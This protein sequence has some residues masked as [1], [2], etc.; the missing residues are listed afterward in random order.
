MNASVSHLDAPSGVDG[1]RDPLEQLADDFLQRHRRGEKP[2]VA[3]Y[4][5][6]FPALAEQIRGVFPALLILEQAGPQGSAGSFGLLGD[7]NSQQRTPPTIGDYQ[8][9]REIGRGAM[10]IVYEA[11]QQSLD[12]RVAL[13]ILPWHASSDSQAVERFRREAKAAARLHHTNIVPVFEVGQAGDVCFYTMQCIQG[14]SLDKVIVELR[15]LVRDRKLDLADELPTERAPSVQSLAL[16]LRD[17]EFAH[18]AEPEVLVAELA[19]PETIHLAAGSTVNDKP[20]SHVSLADSGQDHLYRS[21]AQIGRQIAEA[22]AY[23]HSRGV[24]HRDIKPSNVLLDAAGVAWVTDFGL[25]KLEDVAITRTGDILGTL[26]YMAPERFQGECDAAADVYS[27]GVTL[28][29]LLALKPPHDGAQRAELI[30]QITQRDPLPLRVIDPAVPRDLELIIHKALEREPQHRYATAAALAEDLRRFLA[31]E[32]ILGR[33]ISMF[34]RFARWVRHNRLLAASLI[35][36]AVLLLLLVVATTL[37]GA[38]FRALAIQEREAR[39]DTTGHLYRAL[40]GEARATRL[41]RREGFRSQAWSLLDQARKLD[42]EVVNPTELRAEAIQSLGDFVGLKPQVISGFPTDVRSLALSPDAK[43]IAVGLASGVIQW[44]KAD[45]GELI[46]KR[47]EHFAAVTRLTFTPEGGLLSADARGVVRAWQRKQ[48]DVWESAMLSDVRSPLLALHAGAGEQRL[49]AYNS[50]HVATLLTIDDLQTKRR[51][52]IDPGLVITSA[53]FNSTASMLAGVSGDDIFVWQTSGG[54]LIKRSTSQLGPLTGVSFSRD[55]QLLLCTGEQGLAVFDLPELRQQTFTR[56]EQLVAGAF[57]RDGR[58]VAVASE[59]RRVTLWSVFGNREIAALSHPGWKPLHT[60]AFSDDERLLASADADSVRIWNLAGASD[61]LNLVGHTSG[62]TSLDFSPDGRRLISTSKDR[63]LSLWDAQSGQRLAITGLSAT[64]QSAVFSSDGRLL[65]AGDSAGKLAIFDAASLAHVLDVP[66]SLG[67][68]H[69][70]RFSDDGKYFAASGAKGLVVWQVK[71]EPAAG[72][73][74]PRIT[75][76]EIKRIDD[77]DCIALAVSPDSQFLAWLNSRGRIGVLVLDQLAQWPS[78]APRAL[79]GSYNLAFLGDSRHLLLIDTN[80]QLVQWDVLGDRATAVIGERGD[81]RGTNLALGPNGQWV[82]IDAEPLRLS[83]WDLV[84]KQQAFVFR[85]ER[86]AISA[87]AWSAA[88]NRLAFG[89]QDGQVAIWDLSVVRKEL[90]GI[91]LD[92][93]N[94]VFEQP[95][96]AAAVSPLQ[97]LTTALEREPKN[98]MLLLRRASL[99]LER[100]NTEQSLA[101]LSKALE[102]DEQSETALVARSNLYARLGK[103]PEAAADALKAV[104]FDPESIR[105][106]RATAML[107][108]RAGDAARYHEHCGE[109]AERFA[110]SSDPQAVEQLLRAALLLPDAT[111]AKRLPRQVLETAVSGFGPSPVSRAEAYT[112]LALLEL[113]SGKAESALSF[114]HRAQED[115]AYSK[116]PSAQSLSFLVQAVAEQYVGKPAVARESLKASAAFAGGIRP[117]T[118]GGDFVIANEARIVLEILTPEAQRVVK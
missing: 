39:V 86:S 118:P 24:I 22:L 81:L 3:E 68:L 18:D 30:A 51:V 56:T 117:A 23:A 65:A 108:A 91:E 44:H 89:T 49:I 77:V 105:N 59:G 116:T 98:A 100:G 80:N 110:E 9:V 1:E 42:S 52:T 19:A 20:P 63:K 106:W 21:A 53:A 64:M 26:R 83:V 61:R 67:G 109:M 78:N 88:G 11:Q 107:L 57:A 27:L 45:T 60:I 28:Y 84:D 82:A 94:E 29:E 58:Q 74:Q 36:S 79:P 101:D 96:V 90:A 7:V 41:A 114:L 76:A 99:H 6:R 104:E 16:S 31:D 85:E 113:R 40:L 71:S 115:P 72:D 48:D 75:L 66:H 43:L 102:A 73:D 50:E 8:L 10:G 69:A 38:S 70:V 112:T 87:T 46:S 111:S 32:P 12:R 93:P 4:A 55:G 14:Q 17:G 5:E 25:A 103:W 54:A 35:G 92:W 62:V 37:A 95:E 15:R 33:R 47:S 97:A 34:E 13:K 2:S